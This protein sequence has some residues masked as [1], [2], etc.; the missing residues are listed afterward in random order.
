MHNNAHPAAVINALAGEGEDAQA[1]P[2]GQL[3]E[4]YCW[5]GMGGWGVTELG[6]ALPPPGMHRTC[7]TNFS[8]SKKDTS[9]PILAQMHAC[10]NFIGKCYDWIHKVFPIMGG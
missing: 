2:H 10:D 9:P 6:L 7:Q 3:Q 8:T 4:G 5:D 1:V